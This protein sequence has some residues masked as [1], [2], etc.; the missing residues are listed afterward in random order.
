MKFKQ[1]IKKLIASKRAN[2]YFFIALSCLFMVGVWWI[3]AEATFVNRPTAPSP[4]VV[5]GQVFALIANG[6]IWPSIFNTLLK[7]LIAFS[8]SFVLGLG[9]AI[10]AAVSTNARNFFSPVITLIRA[11][12]TVGVVLLLLILVSSPQVAAVTIASMMVFPLLY[13]NFYTAIGQT[14]KDLLQMA[15][16][17]KIPFIKQLSGIYV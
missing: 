16:V 4:P 9:F 8:I 2:K 6:T 3:W 15:K 14:D 17:H 7:V 5:F 10:L 12:P 13:E 11:L 1:K